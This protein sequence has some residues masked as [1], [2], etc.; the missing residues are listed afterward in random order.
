M[1]GGDERRHDA[2]NHARDR[3][4]DE[5]DHQDPAIDGERRNARQ[6]DERGRQNRSEERD[7]PC[8]GEDARRSTQ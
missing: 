3:R 8:R 1:I 5:R 4:E 2:E 6:P 7:G